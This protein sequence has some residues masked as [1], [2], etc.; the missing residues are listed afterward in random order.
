MRRENRRKENENSKGVLYFFCIIL[1]ISIIT[2][3]IT[4]ITYS[5]NTQILSTEKSRMRESI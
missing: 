5:K 4:F 3:I 1:C 2:F